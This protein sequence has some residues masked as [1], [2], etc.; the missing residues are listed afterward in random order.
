MQNLSDV[1]KT[2]KQK[3][4]KI[5][6]TDLVNVIKQ[7]ADD[8]DVRSFWATHEKELRPDAFQLKMMDLHEF[9]QQKNVLQV[10]ISHY[11]PDIIHS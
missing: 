8:D 11:I 9:V 1:L 7:I 6:E 5:E 4:S 3:Y 10:G 2:L